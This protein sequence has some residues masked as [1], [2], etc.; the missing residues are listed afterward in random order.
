MQKILKNLMLKIKNLRVHSYERYKVLRSYP[1]DTNVF[2]LSKDYL[3]IDIATGGSSERKTIRII[4]KLKK[5]TKNTNL[6]CSGG[7]FQNVPLNNFIVK[8]KIFK[9][10]Y[11]PMANSDAGLSL[12]AALYILKTF[13]KKKPRK[14]S[15]FT[16]YLGPSFS[17]VEIKSELDSYRLN[18]KHYVK[19]L[20]KF[21]ALKILKG[22]VVGWFWK[23]MV[24]DR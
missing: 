20:E 18:Y 3:P 10:Y 9:N 21:V 24:L 14:F 1:S 6:V 13:N 15:D 12:G 7:L 23:N 4:K 11:F 2:R 19:G 16:P 17:N 5:K 22:S 8:S